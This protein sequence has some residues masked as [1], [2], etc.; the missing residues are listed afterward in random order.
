MGKSVDTKLLY[1][2]FSR[3]ETSVSSMEAGAMAPEEVLHRIFL[4]NNEIGR[5]ARAGPEENARMKV[6]QLWVNHVT[7]AVKQGRKR[8]AVVALGAVKS[9]MAETAGTK[10]R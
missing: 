3:V 2:L 4:L 5:L 1:D 7:S 8:E 10:V 6:L 9:A